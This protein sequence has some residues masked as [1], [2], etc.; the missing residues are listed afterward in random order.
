MQNGKESRY[1]EISDYLEGTAMCA[2]SE[3]V[4]D[5]CQHDPRNTNGIT[6]NGS[7][8]RGVHY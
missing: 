7:A 6:T 1:L 5:Y 3:G 8:A 4:V 2:S